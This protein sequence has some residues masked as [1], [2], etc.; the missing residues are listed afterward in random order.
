LSEKSTCARAVGR[1]VI[2]AAVDTSRTRYDI[3]SPSEE[4]VDRGGPRRIWPVSA[5]GGRLIF[6]RPGN[7]DG[8]RVGRPI[9]YS[10]PFGGSN[11]CNGTRPGRV[12]K[13]ILQIIAQPVGV[14]A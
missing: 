5:L 3:F 6:G 8:P 7:R 10:S 11:V 9:E 2:R 12:V 1:P 14:A 13:H 4:A